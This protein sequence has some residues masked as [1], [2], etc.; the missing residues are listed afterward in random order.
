MEDL[1]KARIIDINDD[2]AI[3]GNDKLATPNQDMAQTGQFQQYYGN[4]VAMAYLALQIKKS[5]DKKV[6]LCALGSLLAMVIDTPKVNVINGK[7]PIPVELT[8]FEGP[9]SDDNVPDT[10]VITTNFADAAPVTKGELIMTSIGDKDEFGS[11]VGYLFYC[12][13]KQLQDNNRD[14]FYKNRFGAL[15]AGL[16]E[17]PV[18][19]SEDGTTGFIDDQLIKKMNK[20]LVWMSR[21]R[22]YMT[23]QAVQSLKNVTMGPHAAFANIFFLLEDFGLGQLRIVKLAIRRFDWI[24]EVFPEY[25]NEI[26][27]ADRAQQRVRD[28]PMEQ[29]AFAKAIW[30]NQFVPHK[31]DD[32]PNLV[33]LCKHALT[34]ERDSYKNLKY[35]DAA[36]EITRRFDFFYRAL[37]EEENKVAEAE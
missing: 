21:P 23:L 35:G 37:K 17:S 3:G 29:R 11:L 10:T 15:T 36:P 4:Q 2:L 14:A 8:G 25:R 7:D 18:L 12:A 5:S 16:I 1:E 34:I 27:A 30:G 33:K 28:L 31:K 19:F 13:N 22:A 20:V 9:T 24:P 32:F 26:L 6:I